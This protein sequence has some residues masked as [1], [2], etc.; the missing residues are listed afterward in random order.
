VNHPSPEELVLNNEHMHKRKQ[1]NE[2][3]EFCILNNI[4]HNNWGT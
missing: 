4:R 2:T 3:N 1:V